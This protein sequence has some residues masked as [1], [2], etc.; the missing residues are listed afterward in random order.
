MKTKISI[1]ALSLVFLGAVSASAQSSCSTSAQACGPSGTK[2]EEAKVITS[3]RSDL[4]TVIGKLAK[5]NTGLST[6]IT[7]VEISQGTNDDESLLFIY[8]TAFAVHAELVANTDPGKLIPELKKQN[9]Q[10]SSNKRQLVASLKKEIKLLEDQAE[11]L[12]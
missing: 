1:I 5:S 11:K 3:M 9:L 8:Q 12:L 10:P 6:Q 7:N 2:T 4:Q